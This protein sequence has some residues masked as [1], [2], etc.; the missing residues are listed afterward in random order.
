M[1][2][3]AE[4]RERRR[5]LAALLQPGENAL[6]GLRRLGGLQVRVIDSMQGRVG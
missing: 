4:R 5:Q 2:S 6:D 3:E 1:L